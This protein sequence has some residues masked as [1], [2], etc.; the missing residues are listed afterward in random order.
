MS[1]KSSVL[2]R[3]KLSDIALLVA[4][5]MLLFWNALATHVSGVFNYTDEMIALLLGI[6]SVVKAIGPWKIEKLGVNGIGVILCYCFL[7]AL[8]LLSSAFQEIQTNAGVI[9]SDIYLTLKFAITLLACHYLLSSES[10]NKL[11]SALTMEGK[12]IVPIMLIFGTANLFFDVGMRMDEYRYGLTPYLFIFNHP[13]VVVWVSIFFCSV[14]FTNKEKN[15]PFI[16]MTFCVIAMTLRS[17]GICWV[18]AMVAIMLFMRSGRINLPV[19]LLGGLFVVIFSWDQIVYYY[20]AGGIDTSRGALQSASFAIAGKYFPLGSGFATF[21][22]AVTASSPEFYSPLYYEYGISNLWGMTVD[23]P[24]FIADTFWPIIFGQFGYLGAIVT[25]CLFFIILRSALN[26]GKCWLPALSLVAYLILCSFGE[27]S[28]FNP[29]SI[30]F[31]ILLN[32]YACMGRQSFDV[33][34]IMVNKI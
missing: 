12:L 29:N 34:Q 3:Y 10:S 28:I 4:V 23:N 11:I 33:N 26:S 14:F 20:S 13:S 24:M 2:S 9:L 1:A 8:G 30:M 31:A 6:A 21:G 16:F 15:G 22:S 5:N 7:V 18:A 27:T 32:A 25:V 19:I 17:K